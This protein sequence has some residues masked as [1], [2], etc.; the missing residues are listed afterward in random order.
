MMTLNTIKLMDLADK[1]GA[2]VEYRGGAKWTWIV[3][4]A[5]RCDADEFL[6]E[7]DP[8]NWDHR[9]VY[10]TEDGISVRVRR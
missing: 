9:G 6:D 5:S 4:F 1:F 7:L 2:T 10:D 8:S 3:G